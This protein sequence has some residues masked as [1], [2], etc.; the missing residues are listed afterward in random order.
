MGL[1]CELSEKAAAEDDLKRILAAAKTIAVVGASSKKESP[2]YKVAQYLIEHGYK[3]FP[4][5]PKCDEVLGEKCYPDLKSIP[6]HVDVVD[7]F[8]KP[9]AVP[10]IVADAIDIGAG[11][12]WMQLGIEHDSAAKTA[13]DAGLNVVMNRCTKMEHA[14]CFKDTN[15]TLS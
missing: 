5:N 10:A 6:E 7:I 15:K 11:T 13:R 1:V 2:V 8:R 9:E 4:V 14:S 3:V 12:V